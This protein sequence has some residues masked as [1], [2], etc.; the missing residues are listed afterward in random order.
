ME[1]ATLEGVERVEDLYIWQLCGQLTVGPSDS[2]T[3]QHRWKN[4]GRPGRKFTTT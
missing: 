3:K 1:L 2:S 4:D